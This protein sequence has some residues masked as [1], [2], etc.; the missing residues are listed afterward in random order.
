MRSN[1]IRNIWLSIILIGV[2]ALVGCNTPSSILSGESVR[3]ASAASTDGDMGYT[4]HVNGSGAASAAPDVVDVRLGVETTS[5]D[6]DE[7]I[8]ENTERMNAVLEA[9]KALEV[10]EEDIQTVNYA[11]SVEQIRDENGRPTDEV[12]YHVHNQ[13][14]VR[15]RDTGKTG[16]LL[17]A[18]LGAGANTV[19][20]V[21]FSVE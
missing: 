4:I 20:G 7:A 3:V 12:R 18:A 15:L 16:Q 19:S 6:A 2:L 11:M 17:E 14:S 5:A 9:I 10:A 1:K 13:I 8:S 21:N